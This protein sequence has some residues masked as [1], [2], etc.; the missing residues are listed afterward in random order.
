MFF[1]IFGKVG[2]DFQDLLIQQHPDSNLRLEFLQMSSDELIEERVGLLLDVLRVDD[3]T[4]E[5]LALAPVDFHV[6]ISL[7][8]DLGL[9]AEEGLE[10]YLLEGK[11]LLGQVGDHGLLHEAVIEHENLG[12]GDQ[13]I[14]YCLQNHLK[15]VADLSVGVGDLSLFLI[16]LFQFF[17]NGLELL[18]QVL[19]GPFAGVESFDLLVHVIDEFHVGE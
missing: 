1:I 11:L 15:L 14:P 10:L 13:L 5:E 7:L 16:D 6:E 18:Q 17:L 4:G 12:H 8:L 2:G 19:I 3:E 9:A